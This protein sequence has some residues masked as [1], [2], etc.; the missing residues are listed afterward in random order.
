MK[1]YSARKGY[2]DIC[3]VLIDYGADVNAI[4]PELLSTVSLSAFLHDCILYLTY[5]LF[6]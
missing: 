2:L 6:L 1:H 4:T 3:R 5:I